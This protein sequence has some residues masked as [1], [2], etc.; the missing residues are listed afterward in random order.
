M[1]HR[2]DYLKGRVLLCDGALNSPLSPIGG[3]GW[4][5]GDSAARN[6][7]PLTLPSL[8]D[9]PLPLPQCGRGAFWREAARR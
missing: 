9:G 3:E 1:T 8:R 4:G 5:E 7:G 6:T 2:L